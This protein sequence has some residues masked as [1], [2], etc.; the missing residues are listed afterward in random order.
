M[1]IAA[2]VAAWL[3]GSTVLLS[4]GRRGLATGLGV[5]AAA[6]AVL[7]FLDGH[8][9]E[10]VVL[11]AGGAVA[12]ALR[13]RSGPPGWGVMPAGSTPRLI[14]AIVAGLFA[15]WIAAAVTGGDDAGLRF[16]IPAVLVV[17][18]LRAMLGAEAAAAST[19]ASGIALTLGAGTLLAADG[20]PAAACTVAALAA[21][22]M[23]ALPRAQTHGA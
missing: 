10:A 20:A 16:A 9:V 3:G 13:F 23:Q 1:T 6:L 19:V 17:L 8:G 12:A 2:A 4:D 7:A 14:L 18:V 11:I 15:L 22:A 5:L 21:A